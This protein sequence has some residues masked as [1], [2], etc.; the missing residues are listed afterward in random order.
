MVPYGGVE[1]LELLEYLL[2]GSRL[3]K[4]IKTV[5]EM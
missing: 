2:R 1:S 4:P 5:S 3:A